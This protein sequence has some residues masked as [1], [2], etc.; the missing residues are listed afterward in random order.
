MEWREVLSCGCEVADQLPITV[1]RWEENMSS[2]SSSACVFRYHAGAQRAFA[3][4][5]ALTSYCFR[6]RVAREQTQP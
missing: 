1:C 5:R 6:Q 2:P 4:A 3:S